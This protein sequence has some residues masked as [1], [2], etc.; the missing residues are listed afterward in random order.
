MLIAFFSGTGADCNQHS[1]SGVPVEVKIV[2]IQLLDKHFLPRS[3]RREPAL[4]WQS[5]KRATRGHQ[6]H[7]TYTKYDG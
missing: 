2:W 7:D 4:S 6:R 1:T 5:M 3:A